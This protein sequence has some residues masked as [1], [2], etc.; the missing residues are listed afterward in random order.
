MILPGALIT[1]EAFICCV[2]GLKGFE[3]AA[4]VP[5]N[6]TL[7]SDFTK[8]TQWRMR[9]D[10][11][12][13]SIQVYKTAMK[14]RR[15]S[16]RTQASRPISSTHDLI[17]TFYVGAHF[18][19]VQET[20][21][22]S[23]RCRYCATFCKKEGTHEFAR[24]HTHTHR[25]THIHYHTPCWQ[26]LPLCAIS[27]CYCGPWCCKNTAEEVTAGGSRDSQRP[28][29][30]HNLE[31]RNRRDEQ[32][33]RVQKGMLGRNVQKELQSDTKGMMGK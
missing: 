22:F 32:T 3:F 9:N 24:T 28:E 21:V 19:R 27:I 17:K 33:E 20:A 29:C 14:D 11:S 26:I 18:L 10:E 15:T 13:F 6:K 2:K 23:V 31:K 8:F 16:A 7:V 5:E 12:I 1:T 25:D 30:K 4:P